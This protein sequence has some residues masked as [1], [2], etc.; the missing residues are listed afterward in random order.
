[1]SDTQLR[2]LQ[3]QSNMMTARG[4]I[5]ATDDTQGVHK[6][7]VRVTPRETIDGVPVVQL[8]GFSSHAKVGSEAHLLFVAGDR[9][10]AV[11]VATNDADARV[12]NI[13]PGEVA[14]F[15]DE[16]DVIVLGRDHHISITTTGTVT[17]KADTKV[18]VETPR[19]ECTGDIIDHCDT[20]SNTNANMRSIYNSHTHHGVQPG[21]GNTSAPNQ[22]QVTD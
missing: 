20:Q 14:L 15:T 13:K 4:V 8:Y 6:V 1:M 2:R 3:R 21:S 9:S 19:L 11:V 12:R 17:V 18:R 22:P 10:R 5:S 16:G 7:Q